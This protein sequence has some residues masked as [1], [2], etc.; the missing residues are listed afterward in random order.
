MPMLVHMNILRITIISLFSASS[1][2]AQAPTKEEAPQNAPKK[3]T[4]TK[5]VATEN[6]NTF[7]EAP[8]KNDYKAFCKHFPP[9]LFAVFGG[10]EGH[11]TMFATFVKQLKDDGITFVSVV[12]KEPAGY[13]ATETH[14]YSHI[15]TTITLSAGGKEVASEGLQ[16]AFKKKDAAVWQYIEITGFTTEQIKTYVPHLPDTFK[17]PEA[18][19]A[20]EKKPEPAKEK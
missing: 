20:E 6:L 1:L 15:H 5:E 8:Y 2:Y 12:C 18:K 9:H 10:Q 14:E 17:L 13:V 4:L 19:K 11:K 3:G 7:I 16:L